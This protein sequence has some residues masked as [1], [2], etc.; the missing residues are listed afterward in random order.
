MEEILRSSVFVTRL[1]LFLFRYKT[2]I[3]THLRL[4]LATIEEGAQFAEEDVIRTTVAYEV[5]NIGIEVQRLLRTHDSEPAEEVVG[6]IERPDELHAEGIKIRLFE[7]VQVNLEHLSAVDHLFHA[8][9]I[10]A[11]MH[12]KLGV[13]V[14]NP[15]H[16]C[17]E[18]VIGDVHRQTRA[19]GYII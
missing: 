10:R 1:R 5:V 13:V 16:R 17:A 8:C 11:E 6:Q 15:F 18:L 7:L 12:E 9:V 3:R 2:G 19:C 4:D 14:H